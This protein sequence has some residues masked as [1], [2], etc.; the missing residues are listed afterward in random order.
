MNDVVIV[1][2]GFSGIGLAISTLLLENGYTVYSTYN[3]KTEDEI[4][5]IKSSLNSDKL[6][7]VKLDITSIEE[8]QLVIGDILKENDGVFAL[9]NNAGIAE[10]SLFKKMTYAQWDN[11][12][13][14]NLWSIFNT[15]QPVFRHMV[16]NNKGRIINISSVNAIKGQF[17]QC[18]YAAAK[19]GVIAFSKS[20]AAEGARNN[21][22]VNVIAPGY[23]D[24]NMMKSIPV[25]AL[26][27]IMG[28]MPL[29]R[30]IKPVEVAS[31]VVY[32]L[33]E[34]SA[35]ITGETI[36]VNGGMVMS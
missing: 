10:D 33:S 26:E 23:T 16:N 13:R 24:T 22:S 12:L 2:G 5:K 31:A 9:V 25:N 36:S 11:V 20:L 35:A 19:A 18:N 4:Y 32:L 3:N 1:T 28:A 8:C 6:H 29:G 21:V 14:T 34:H 27:K 17:G 15:T 30:L 7:S